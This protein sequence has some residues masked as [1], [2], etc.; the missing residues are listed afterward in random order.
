MNLITGRYTRNPLAL[1]DVNV[2][3]SFRHTMMLQ[4][5]ISVEILEIE[6]LRIAPS[7]SRKRMILVFYFE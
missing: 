1:L 3:T 7:F 5:Y 2:T 4:I 6:L